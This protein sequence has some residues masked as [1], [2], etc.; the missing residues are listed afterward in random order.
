MHVYTGKTVIDNGF[1]V[2]WHIDAEFADE[3][4][5]FF[6]PDNQ[7]TGI[8]LHI[9]NAQEPSY[10]LLNASFGHPDI[11]RFNTVEE[12]YTYVIGKLA[13]RAEENAKERAYFH[14]NRA[15]MRNFLEQ[16]SESCA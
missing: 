6:D 9:N 14:K 16:K 5:T 2:T 11:A 15:T 3:K 13:P 1:G 12:A 8:R 7:R 10:R 4:V